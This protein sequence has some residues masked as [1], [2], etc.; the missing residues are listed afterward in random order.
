VTGPFERAGQE[1]AEGIVVFGEE[2]AGHD[3]VT[4]ETGLRT[5]LPHRT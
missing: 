5:S 1:A 3:V 2:D 4:V